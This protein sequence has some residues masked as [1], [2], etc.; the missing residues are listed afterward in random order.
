MPVAQLVAIPRSTDRSEATFFELNRAITREEADHACS[1]LEAD[2]RIHSATVEER[3]RQPGILVEVWHEEGW[4]EPKHGM[5][6]QDFVNMVLRRTLKL[7]P[8]SSR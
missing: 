3:G 1:K 2:H 7:K 4:A 8:K 6:T 5:T